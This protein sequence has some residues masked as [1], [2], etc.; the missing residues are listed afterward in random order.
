MSSL[1]KHCLGSSGF[2]ALCLFASQANAALFTSTDTPINLPDYNQPGTHI[3]QITVNDSSLWSI[4]DINVKLNFT[5]TYI[6]DLYC[7]LTFQ[8]TGSSQ[9]ITVVLM[10]QISASNNEWNSLTVWLDDS[11]TTSIQTAS[12]VTDNASYNPTGGTT[13]LA[14]YNG[15]NPNGTW[16]LFIDDMSSGD[17]STLNSWSLDITAV[18]EPSTWAM[19][20]FGVCF[21]GFGA[22]RRFHRWQNSKQSA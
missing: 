4:T 16:T 19:G 1:L 6:G 22:A 14:N 9:P 17:T 7:S 8:P 2:L 18:P 3:S 15:F 11:A 20:A 21:A 12:S 10:N 5:S 13:T